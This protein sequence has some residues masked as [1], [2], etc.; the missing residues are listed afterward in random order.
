MCCRSIVG[1]LGLGFTATE[2]T[3]SG[4]ERA[5]MFMVTELCTGGSLRETILAQMIAGR[6]VVAAT[7]TR[8]YALLCVIMRYALL[9][10]I[11]RYADEYSCFEDFFT[12]LLAHMPGADLTVRFRV[13]C[14]PQETHACAREGT[15]FCIYKIECRRGCRWCTLISRAWSGRP[16]WPTGWP[17]CMRSGPRSS[18]ATSSS[19]TCCCPKV[20]LVE[21]RARSCARAGNACGALLPRDA[22]DPT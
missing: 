16:K 10:V 7:A 14:V 15:F 8:R 2:G 17:S 19:T 21:C 11:M 12:P 3:G 18:T 9:C 6:K 4:V 1:V 22:F 20:L 13:L 5:S